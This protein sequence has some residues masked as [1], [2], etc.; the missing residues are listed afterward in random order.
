MLKDLDSGA[1]RKHATQSS[2]LFC[3][4]YRLMTADINNGP[5]TVVSKS[6]QAGKKLSRKFHKK[7]VLE[8]LLNQFKV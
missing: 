8:I 2:L 5:Q 6:K 7:K 4:I 1:E 3:I